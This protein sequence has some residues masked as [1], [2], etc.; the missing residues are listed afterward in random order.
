MRHTGRLLS[1]AAGDIQRI[2]DQSCKTNVALVWWLQ[3]YFGITNRRLH[4]L[5]I[6]YTFIYLF[7]Y[8]TFIIHLY[9]TNLVLLM[10]WITDPTD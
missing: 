1:R 5:P 2:R 3:L 4:Q 7:I 8:H 10:V 6:F 9:N